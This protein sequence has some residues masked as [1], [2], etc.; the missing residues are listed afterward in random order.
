MWGQSFG[1]QIK[2]VMCAPLSCF[3]H[4]IYPVW[5]LLLGKICDKIVSGGFPAGSGISDFS[6]TDLLEYSSLYKC[7]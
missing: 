3:L 6:A 4:Q 2:Y 5:L 7:T 1:L